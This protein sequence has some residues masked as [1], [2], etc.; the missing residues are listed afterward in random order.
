MDESATHNH[1]TPEQVSKRKQKEGMAMFTIQ[2]ETHKKKSEKVS[3]RFSRQQGSTTVFKMAGGWVAGVM[4][5]D[6]KIG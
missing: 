1:I 5:L 3:L 4:A 6:G 2:I